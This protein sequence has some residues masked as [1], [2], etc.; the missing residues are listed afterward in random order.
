MLWRFCVLVDA[1]MECYHRDVLPLERQQKILQQ[2]QE[3]GNIRTMDIASLLNVTD[4]TVRKDF[5]AL[6]KRGYLI[7]VHGGATRPLKIREEISLTERQLKNRE[8]KTAIA[9]E[10]A[11]RIQPN[12]TIFLD[13]SSTV[14]TLT[15]FLPDYPLTIVTNALNVFSALDGRPNLD[16]ICTGGLYDSRSRSFIGLIAE[17][18]LRRFNIH[19]MFFSGSGL[20]LDRGISETNNRQAVFKERVVACAED[21]VFLA[22][23]TKLGQKAAFFFAQVSDLTCLITDSHADKKILSDLSGSGVEVIEA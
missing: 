17:Q 18:S 14:L 23:H 5:E 12:E 13:A 20:H 11:R 16:L 21:V 3:C 8:E 15:E 2:L 22:D 1:G 19:R 9:R 4:E 7:R 10:A 6:E